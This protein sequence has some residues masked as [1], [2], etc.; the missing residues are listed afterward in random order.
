MDALDSYRNKV[1]SIFCEM[2]GSRADALRADRLAKDVILRIKSVFLEQYSPDIASTLGMHLSDWIAD[3]AFLVALHLF[4]ER[5]TDGEIE[6]GIDMFLGHAPNHICAA[7]KIT[8]TY[9][10]EDFPDS[11]PD[12][13]ENAP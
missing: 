12:T 4:P 3:G 5:F 9:V 7:C 10:W 8:S 6:A 1:D 11:D 13:W 2:A